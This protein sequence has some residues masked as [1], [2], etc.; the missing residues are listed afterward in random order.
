VFTSPD[1]RAAGLSTPLAAG[2]GA[3][4]L[5][6]VLPQAHWDER[7]AR[8]LCGLA[9]H[10]HPDPRR[11]LLPDTYVGA[12][13]L[14]PGS[15][16]SPPP[17][18]QP[19]LLGHLGTVH[20][21]VGPV[22]AGIIE[23]GH[24]AFSVMGET[25]LQLDLRLG[26]NH[27]GLEAAV[28]GRDV[29]AAA[30]VVARTCGA[31]SAS[32]QEALAQAVEAIAGWSPDAA[33]ASVRGAILELERIYN[34]LSDLA[35]LATGVGLSVL[36]HQGLAL[37]ER[38]LRLNAAAFGHRYLFDC[39]RPGQVRRPWRRAEVVGELARLASAS[40]AWSDRLFSNVGFRDRAQGAGV[41]PAAA[42]RALGAVGPAA[43]ASGVATDVRSEAAVAPYV[44]AF[45][46]PVQAS[47][48][49]VLARAE[50]RRAELAQA[51]ALAHRWLADQSAAAG[52]T[53]PP[54]FDPALTGQAVGLTES[55]R[56]ALVH[57][58]HLEGGRI[59]RYHMRTAS[60]ANWPLIMI[61]ARDNPIGDFPLINKSLELCYA[62]ADR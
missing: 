58:V 15:A 7:E 52:W 2:E 23:T 20:V 32:H 51:F 13:P 56:G 44:G 41:I 25:V 14:A 17:A 1:G 24:F 33:S 29:A 10:N 26:W 37:K 57:Y 21:P 6:A 61:A 5:A 11:L 46:A 48:G 39:I 4:S 60:F 62:C 27:R 50:V 34:H 59:V 3:E 12:P 36:A 49:D 30:P 18:W 47:A 53:V 28:V 35:Q 40:A 19:R 8:D 55:P 42:V 54:A 31:C 16:A 9:L 43:R 45:A 38:A 22:H